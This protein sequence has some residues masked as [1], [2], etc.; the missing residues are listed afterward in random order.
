M[1]PTSITRHDFVETNGDNFLVT[2]PFLGRMTYQFLTM[3]EQQIKQNFNLYCFILLLAI[4]VAFTNQVRVY[5]F[6]FSVMV[7]RVVLVR[8][9][10][11]ENEGSNFVWELLLF[12]FSPPLS[13]TIHQNTSYYLY[14]SFCQMCPC[15]HLIL[16]STFRYTSGH[17]PTTV[18]P[19]GYC[20]Y[21]TVTSFS[22]EDT[23]GITM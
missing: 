16:H 14:M 11:Q 10:A 7:I 12:I 6:A 1:D 18:Y 9:L 23:T 2:I 4:F 5:F 3:N 8:L 20:S 13:S 19:V 22:Q 21:K 17:T 15:L